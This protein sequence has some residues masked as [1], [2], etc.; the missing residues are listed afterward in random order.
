MADNVKESSL[1]GHCMK[2]RVALGLSQED[3]ATK[4]GVPLNYVK[5]IEWDSYSTLNL[6]TIAMIFEVLGYDAF[7]MLDPFS[8]GE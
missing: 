7:F 8:K 5:L 2:L 3:L 6:A 4:A 1:G